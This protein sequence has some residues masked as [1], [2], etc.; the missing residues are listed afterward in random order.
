MEIRP[1][2]S[3]L[4]RHKTAAALIVVEVA[5]SCAIICNA[6]FLVNA[7]VQRMDRPSGIVEQ[8]LLHIAATSL[9]PGRSPDVTRRE[10]L[11]VLAAVPGVKSVTSINQM[12]YGNSTWASS[13][14]LTP[15]Q[16]EPTREASM[17]LDD[18]TLVETFG[19]QV[20]EGRD[21]EPGEFVDIQAL[22]EPSSTAGVPAALVTRSLAEKLFPGESALGKDI[23]VFGDSPIRIVG[24]VSQLIQPGQ[25]RIVGDYEAMIFPVRVSQGD[26]V[27][28][29]EEGRRA[30][31][32]KAAVDALLRAE[33]ARI[34]DKQETV[35]DMRRAFYSRDRSV[36]WLL[37]CVCAAL[38]VVTALGIVGLAS[39][40]VQQRTRQIGVRRALG[41]TRGQILR[42]FQLENLILATLGILLG[43]LLA[44]GINQLLMSRYELPRLPWQY[45][46]AGAVI[47]WILGQVAVL[48]PAR[49]AA[50]VPPAIATRS[51]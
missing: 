51:A 17:Y 16:P 5:L 15:E 43:M 44:F 37:V 18:G 2:L 6:I 7:R 10:D 20:L 21:F 22:E 42:Y 24:V 23:Y 45:L 31:V 25:H 32:L 38:L 1:V 13:I 26:Y 27:L 30:E 29:T 8:E 40:W 33:P 46:P 47:L 19:M 14:N 50:S 11:A 36:V 9:M 35:T 4:L 48:G 41:A 49:R 28:R 39:F 34:I 12:P 3:A